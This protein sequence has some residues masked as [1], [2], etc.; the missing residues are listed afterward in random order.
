MIFQ[1]TSYVRGISDFLTLLALISINLGLINLVPLPVLDG[2]HL[3][4]FGLEGIIRRPLPARFLLAAQQ[5]GLAVI[6]VL[7]VLITYKDI[8]RLLGY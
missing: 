2:G 3:L 4:F 1:V 8:L 6:A 7:F 5:A